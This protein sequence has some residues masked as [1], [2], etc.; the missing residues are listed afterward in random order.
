MSKTNKTSLYKGEPVIRL[1]KSKKDS[2]SLSGAINRNIDR[3]QHICKADNP[4]L[5]DED[6]KWKGLGV[7]VSLTIKN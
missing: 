4:H 7:G 3:Y 2:E 5:N 6:L 1:E